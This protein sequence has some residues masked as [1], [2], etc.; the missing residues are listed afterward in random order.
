MMTRVETKPIQIVLVDDHQVV[1]EGLRALL[2]AQPDFRLVGESEDGTDAIRKIGQLRP[3]VVV[4]DLMLRGVQGLEVLRQVHRD[5]P[6]ARV[7]VLSMH[8]DLAYVNE[9]LQNGA[10]AYVLKASPSSE[11]VRGIREAVAGR[12]YLSPPLSEEEVDQYARQVDNGRLDPYETLTTREREVLQL[13]AQGYTNNQIAEILCIGRRTVETH[14]A[15]MMHKLKLK[16]QAELVAYAIRK[17]LIPADR[18]GTG[19]TPANH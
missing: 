12:R 18:G 9:A 16:N 14:R 5:V 10:A 19:S 1:R 7:V 15:S 17:G 8:H 4:L 6:R 2:Q 3:D 11:V 13:A